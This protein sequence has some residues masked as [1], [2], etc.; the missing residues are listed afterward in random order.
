MRS[1]RCSIVLISFVCN[2]VGGEIDSVV[3]FLAVS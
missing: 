1:C 2:G 3:F